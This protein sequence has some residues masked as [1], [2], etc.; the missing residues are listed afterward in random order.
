M[1]LVEF[2]LAERAFAVEV[3]SVREVSRMV[4][5]A[6]L[7][8]L[9]P[10]V[11]GVINVHGITTPVLD[12]RARLGLP[13]VADIREAALLIVRSERRL[14]AVPVDAVTGVIRHDG[15]FGA[16]A[17]WDCARGVIYSGER[18]ITVL[19]ADA[20]PIPAMEPLLAAQQNLAS[21]SFSLRQSFVS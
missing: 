6:P 19:D 8:G 9:P 16:S 1:S 15:A 2:R 20:L 4:T 18:L 21:G 17:A 5:I 13:L 14:M 10:A 11:L 7:V 12:L 3:A